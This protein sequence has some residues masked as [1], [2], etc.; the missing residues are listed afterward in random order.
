MLAGSLIVAGCGAEDPGAEPST[1]SASSEAPAAEDPETPAA[2][3]WVEVTDP[4]TGV[5]FA[6]PGEAQQNSRP[7][8]ADGSTP[9][10][11]MY[12]FAMADRFTMA[13]AFSEAEG[14]EYSAAGLRQMSAAVLTQLEGAGAQDVEL[15]GERESTVDGRP[16]YDYELAFTATNGKQNVWFV[17]AVGDGARSV[18]LQSIGFTEV[19]DDA[20][21]TE[22]GEYHER[23]V[24]TLAFP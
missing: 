10:T 1:T 13:A 3:E 20:A 15:S 21:R 7:A 19:G 2:E 6:L 23:F 14:A 22:I 12:Q 24:A 4:G 18:M 9:A 16:V 17:R 11:T 5:T 8:A